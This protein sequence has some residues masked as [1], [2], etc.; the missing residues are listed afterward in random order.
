MKL[1]RQV[2]VTEKLR[3]DMEEK[4]RELEKNKE[5]IDNL[6]K[7]MMQMNQRIEDHIMSSQGE[8]MPEKKRKTLDAPEEYIPV[9]SDGSPIIGGYTPSRMPPTKD[10][11]DGK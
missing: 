6:E 2:K 3:K 10:P 8:K 7:R 4:T 9:S 11:R 1:A 5:K